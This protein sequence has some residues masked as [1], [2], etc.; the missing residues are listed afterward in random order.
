MTGPRLSVALY[1]ADAALVGGLWL[2]AGQAPGPGAEFGVY[3]PL[4]LI[5]AVGSILVG[6]AFHARHGDAWSAHRA[7]AAALLLSAVGG[8]L[9]PLEAILISYGW[10][11]AALGNASLVAWSAG[12]NV[13]VGLIAVLSSALLWIGI[14]RSRQHADAG[15]VRRVRIVIWVLVAILSL[16]SYSTAVYIFAIGSLGPQLFALQSLVI[17]IVQTILSTALTVTLVG[18][19]MSDER[20]NGAWWLAGAGRLVSLGGSFVYPL[21]A[22]SLGSAVGFSFYYLISQGFGVVGTL[23]LLAAFALGL[24]AHCDPRNSS[25][26][27]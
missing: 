21:L 11:S 27:V 20:P 22:F 14:H 7:I 8:T 26:L 16:G 25:E 9:Y 5:A 12:L 15:G 19:A 6:A 13:A 1:L 4:R 24:P 2:V 18:G 17:G 3:G 23:G 10:L